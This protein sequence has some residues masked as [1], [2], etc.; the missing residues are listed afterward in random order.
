MAIN[1]SVKKKIDT[2][3]G[4]PKERYYAVPKTLQSKGDGVDEREL[5]KEMEHFSSVSAGD[6]LSVLEQL[7]GRIAEHLRN[8]RTVNIRGLGV[9]YVGVSSEGVD[10]PE[11]C[12]ADKVKVTRVCYRAEKGLTDRVK[13][14]K[15]VSIQLNEEKKKEKVNHTNNQL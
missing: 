6:V 14:A 15:F 9:F 4:E 2:S 3:S 5:A 7:S 12:T 11:E 13:R 8:G 1:Y 10:T